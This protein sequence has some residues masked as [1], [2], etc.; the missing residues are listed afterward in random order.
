VKLLYV[1]AGQAVHDEASE[2]DR[3]S[4]VHQNGTI[5]PEA[6]NHIEACAGASPKR[7]QGPAKGTMTHVRTRG[8]DVCT[9]WAHCARSDI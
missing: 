8:S 4:G 1:P 6:S 9:S 2:E 5:W 7:K 3:G